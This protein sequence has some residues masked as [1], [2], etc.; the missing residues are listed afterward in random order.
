MASLN[1]LVGPPGTGKTT[2]ATR[3]SKIWIDGGVPPQ[4]IAY[5]AF[6]KAAAKEAVVRIMEGE[7]Y[8]SEDAV[9]E[10]FPLF[11]TIHSLAFMGLKQAKPDLQVLS[12]AHMRDFSKETGY[13]GRLSSSSW[14]DISDAFQKTEANGESPW[15]QAMAAYM[16]SRVTARSPQEIAAA[17]EEMAPAA[18]RMAFVEIDLYRAF[19]KKYEEFKSK[20]GLIDF[21]DMLEF[22]VTEMQPLSNVRRVV[23]DE[24]QDLSA[25]HHVLL[26]RIFPQAEQVWY[27]GDEDQ[28]IYSFSGAEASLFLQRYRQASRRIILRQTHRFGDEMVRYSRKIIERVRDRIQKNV[29]GLEGRHGAVARSGRF[30]P[31]TGDVLVLHRHVQGCQEM[32]KQFIESGKPFRNERGVDP[33]GAKQ[34][35]QAWRAMEELASGKKA[36]LHAARF[37]ISDLMQSVHLKPEGGKVRMVV[38]G[39]KKKIETL[40]LPSSTVH[41]DELVTMGILTPDG[42]HAI[43][44]RDYNSFKHP[45]DLDFYSR[46]T[47]NGHDVEA[48]RMPVITTIHGSKGRQAESVVVCSEMSK[49]C[50]GDR[51]TE[52]RLA[53]V[54]ATRTK[55]NLMVMGEQ[56]VEWATDH[57]DYPEL[58]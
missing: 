45:E 28:C 48:D 7:T 10:N 53:Y 42:A 16:L 36:L 21:T 49:R 54:A 1:C 29:I 25:I 11:R 8:L 44:D 15:D 13:E 50:W 46:V 5:L 47:H 19:T 6:T 38:H 57:Y 34:R 3:L 14:E 37:L 26:D 18:R 23:V 12:P 58:G 24:A 55:T 17:R 4:T 9:K 51:D 43:R 52:H 27:V 41:L 40:S 56:R 33:L 20:N 30:E 22:A 32:A 35:I 31:P 39:G 2:A